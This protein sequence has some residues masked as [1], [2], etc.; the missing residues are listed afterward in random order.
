MR[1]V[2]VCPAGSAQ[3]CSIVSYTRYLMRHPSC[4]A[5]VDYIV[6]RL[7]IQFKLVKGKRYERDLSRLD[8]MSASRFLLNRNLESCLQSAESQQ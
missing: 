6:Q 2:L 7:V 4:H 5:Q 3:R 1:F 8:C